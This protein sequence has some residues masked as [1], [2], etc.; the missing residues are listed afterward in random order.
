MFLGDCLISWKSKKQPIISLSSVE[1][2]NTALIKTTRE[3]MRLKGFLGELFILVSY[4]IKI[5]TGSQ[6]VVELDCH[7]ILL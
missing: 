7:V 6:V 3:L 4:P 2:K 5:C 1:A